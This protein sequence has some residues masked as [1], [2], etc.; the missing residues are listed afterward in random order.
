[1]IK[2]LFATLHLYNAGKPS[3]ESGSRVVFLI[4][5]L[6]ASLPVVEGGQLGATESP[7]Q[8]FESSR[9]TDRRHDDVSAGKR[10]DTS[11]PSGIFHLPYQKARTNDLMEV[12]RKPGKIRTAYEYMSQ[13]FLF[14]SLT[15]RLRGCRRR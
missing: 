3:C 11:P 1:M 6:Q 8:K 4:L 15:T 9:V 5:I 2:T 13:T 7:I 10:N 14:S 12:Q